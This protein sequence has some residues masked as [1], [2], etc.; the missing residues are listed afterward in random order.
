MRFVPYQTKL[1]P[2]YLVTFLNSKYGIADI[3]RRSRQSIN[4]TNVNPEEV[5]EID[6]PL[7]D[8]GFQKQLRNTFEKAYEGL[9][10]SETLYAK[11][12][13]V[14]LEELGLTNFKPATQ[15][16]NIKSFVQS[17]ATS[18]RLDAEYYQSI[19]ED[20]LRLIFDYKCG[21][22]KLSEICTIKDANYKPSNEEEYQYIELSDIDKS[23]GITGCTLDLGSNLPSRAR[24]VVNA[25]DVIVS[26]IE[27]SLS[28]CALVTKEYDNALCSTGFYVIKSGTINSETLLVLMKS[29]LL[30][31]I[32]KQNCS[33]TILTAI[34][35]NEFSNLPIPTI[36]PVT[37]AKIS[38]LVQRSFSLKTACGKLL[39]LAKRA[40]EIAIEEDEDS[41]LAYIEQATKAI[42]ANH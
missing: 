1:L 2:E 16:T 22:G 10:T 4:Q 6:I 36:D 35:K 30:Q 31:S 15:N 17:F 5:K 42:H 14:L 9:K 25:D 3:K 33:G 7:I 28:N 34:N 32:L 29:E 23:G 13:E 26:S 12:E 18:G 38:Q 19:Y 37:Q 8:L 40:V 41:G 21:W 27:G 24:R 20:Y 39:N 11:A